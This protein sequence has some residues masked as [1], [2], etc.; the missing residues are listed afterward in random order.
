MCFPVSIINSFYVSAEY[1]LL[2]LVPNVSDYLQC[3]LLMFGL[4]L[5][6]N[7]IISR[8]FYYE[9]SCINSPHT[10][11]VISNFSRLFKSALNRMYQQITN[12]DIHIHNRN[13]EH[14]FI[15]VSSARFT[16][17]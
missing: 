2:F 17:Y 12:Y 13:Y 6:P 10:Y 3:Y 4:P 11:I 16:V 5:I 1:N 14:V 7:R 8:N 9:I 15:N